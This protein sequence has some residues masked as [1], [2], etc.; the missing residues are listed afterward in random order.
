MTSRVFS[1]ED[2]NISKISVTSTR[3]KPY[4]DLD[5]SFTASDVGN[6]FKKTEGAAVKQAIKTL[7]NSNKLDKPFDP[8]FGVDLRRFLF[9]LADGQT[10]G[11]ITERVKSTIEAY[12]PRASVRSIK[13]GVQEDINA[14][15]VLLTFS[16]KN[17]DQTITL[18]TTISRLR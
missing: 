7:L 15:N 1:L 18:E 13:V 3:I 16:I 4:K 12:E 11:R 2:A 6:I 5:L 9:E 17:T 14:V 8:N 10:G